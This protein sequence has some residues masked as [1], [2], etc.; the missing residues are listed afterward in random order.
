MYISVYLSFCVAIVSWVG[1]GIST[2]IH[3]SYI[4]YTTVTGYFL[5]DEASTNTSTFS[6]I[7]TNFGLINRT[8]ATDATYDPNGQK[9]QWQRFENQIFRLNRESGRKVQYKL[10]FMGRHG[11]GYHNAAESYYGTPAWN[12]YWSLVDGNGTVRWDDAQVT[13]EGV[14][15]ALAVNA[16]WASELKIQKVPPPR[17]YYTSP[18]T[19]CL[20]TANLTFS[21]LDLPSRHPFVPVVKEFLREGISG[22]TCDRRGS[23][24]YI[25]Q[26]FPNYRIEPGFTETDQLWQAYRREVEIDQDIRSKAVLDDVFSTDDETYISI[27][28]HSGEIASLLRVLGHRPFRLATGAVIPVL[29]K[30]ET[31]DGPAPITATVPY[32][33][34]W[35]LSPGQA[36]IMAVVHALDDYYL[37]ITLLITIAYQLFFF[38]I[39][40]SLKFDKLTDF[41]GGTNFVVLAILTLAFSG[42]NHARQIVC[43][44]FIMLWGA[45]LSGFLLFRIIKTGKDDR[46]D[47]KRDKFWSFLGFWVFQMIW[48][49]IV[50]LPVTILNSPNVTQFDQ[51]A[52]GTGRDIA[53]VI[54]FA[55]GF[56]LESVSDVQKYIFRSKPENKGKVC[57]VGFFT[58]TRHPN[59]FGE[60]IIQFSIFMIAVSPSAYGYVTGGAFSAQYAAILGPFFLTLLLMFVS[61]LTL[62]ER[63]G[64][65][66][67]YKS[68]NHWESF[69]RY[70][71]RTSILIPFPPQLY[72]P[73]PTILKRTLFLEFPI[74]VFDPAKHADQ[75]KIRE[76]EAEE[77]NSNGQ[78]SGQSSHDGHAD[79]QIG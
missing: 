41:A 31:V 60:I 57:D 30:A 7:D 4:N 27:T 11:E 15:Q 49:W 35:T 69:S 16:F 46:F 43:S 25:Q 39:A 76:R 74:Y 62:Q 78:Q 2:P 51:P 42:H 38:S 72:E 32:E 8:Y 19:R 53:G 33:A 79:G 6:F 71:K 40:F 65:K 77:G 34:I 45:R 56:I 64:A 28:S 12:C 73:M 9:T 37:A 63:P 61:G 18:L 24:S 36:N 14:K 10:V 23:K 3:D 68:G 75:N 54:L 70:T 47:D 66:K 20:T 1:V 22:H 50:S 52:F 67:R 17:S 44:L 58:W 55:I 21:G 13:P 59:Y 5:Q 29:V 48:V 26:A